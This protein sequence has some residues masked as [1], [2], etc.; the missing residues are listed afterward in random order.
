M[1]ESY[2]MVLFVDIHRWLFFSCCFFL[3]VWFF[4]CVSR[5]FYR[6]TYFFINEI[7][8]SSRSIKVKVIVPLSCILYRTAPSYVSLTSSC[9]W[10]ITLF[11]VSQ[12]KLHDLSGLHCVIVYLLGGIWHRTNTITS[13]HD[14]NQWKTEFICIVIWQS[15]KF[16]KRFLTIPNSS[17][18]LGNFEKK[19]ISSIKHL[20]YPVPTIAY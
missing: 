4:L 15:E 19:P 6:V 17:A 12:R 14:I 2:E 16:M 18:R 8:P 5:I 11:Y 20:N 10:K 13:K 7:P 1:V 9:V 3:E